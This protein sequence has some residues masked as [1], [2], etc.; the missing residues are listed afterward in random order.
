MVK[1]VMTPPLRGVKWSLAAVPGC[2][3]F[4]G[5][6][7]REPTLSLTRYWAERTGA[8]EGVIAMCSAVSQSP[9]I[10]WLVEN[11]PR[12]LDLLFRTI[13]YHPSAPILIADND[14]NYRDASA[15]AGK[16]LGLPREKIIGRQMDDFAPPSFKPRVS[17]LWQAFLEQGEQEGTLQLVGPDGNPREVEYTAKGNVLPVRHALVL[18]DKTAPAETEHAF[19]SGIPSWVRDYALYLLDIEGRVAAW[20]SGAARIF[21]YSPDEVIGQHVSFLH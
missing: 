3:L 7:R 15:G 4:A 20:Y 13:V 9:A 8:R 18:R 2:Q 6:F 21:G 19:T 12:E 1:A 16:L 14:G 10:D 5:C 11:G 17:Q